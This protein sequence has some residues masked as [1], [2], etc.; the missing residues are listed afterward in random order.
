MK[1]FEKY[2]TAEERTEAFNKYCKEHEEGF[3]SPYCAFVWLD[4]EAEEDAVDEVKP[5][6]CPFC[7]NPAFVNS[8]MSALGCMMYSIECSTCRYRSDSRSSSKEVVATHNRICKAVA[9]YNKE[10]ENAE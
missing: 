5:L 2:K 1:N 10:N 3:C 6:P 9:A 8:Y 7:G 4:A